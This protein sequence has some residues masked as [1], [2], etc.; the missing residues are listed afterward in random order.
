VISLAHPTLNDLDPPAFVRIAKRTGFDAVNLRIMH[1]DMSVRASTGVVPAF[2][3]AAGVRAAADALAETDL[4]VLDVEV[5][6][7]DRQTDV[8]AYRPLFEVGA[9]FGARYAVAISF[10]AEVARVAENYAAVCDAAAPYGLTVV[11]EFMKRGGI[12]TLDAARRVVETAAQPNGGLMIDS[13]HFF[14]S[15]AVPADLASIDPRLLPYMQLADLANFAALRAADPPERAAWTKRLP[16]EGD[17]PLSALL[18]ALPA[19]IPI[20]VEV[21]GTPGSPLEE[22][23]RYAKRAYEAT[24]A[25]TA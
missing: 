24:R 1:V 11:L 21:P 25:V 23:E 16:G 14:R 2:R 22:A 19:D 18:A 4:P 17:L 6:C 13:L 9:R 5:I 20:S 8:G 15:G 3:D 12:E 7:I 10:D